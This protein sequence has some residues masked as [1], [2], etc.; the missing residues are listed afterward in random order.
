MHSFGTNAILI[1]LS[2]LLNITIARLLGPEA[3]GGYDLFGAASALL[4]VL[5]GFSLPSG[6]VYV[7]ALATTSLRSMARWS[8]LTALVQSSVV[9][10]GLAIATNYQVIWSFLPREVGGGI[11]LLLTVHVFFGLLGSYWR[12]ILVGRQEIVPANHITLLT[13]LTDAVLLFGLV[14]LLWAQD[15]TINLH[16]IIWLTIIS[17]IVSN[18]LLMRRLRT[19]LLQSTEGASG[20]R[21]AVRYSAPCYLG[22]LIQFFNYRLDIFLVG[23]FVGPGG[24]GLYAL[25]VSLAQL[26]WLPST[27]VSTV[28]LP[29]VAGQ[30]GSVAHNG[31]LTARA[32]RFSLWIGIIG[33]ITFSLVIIPVLP[34]AYGAA[35][36]GSVPAL[37]W[38]M[39]GI[40]VI[41]AAF[42]PASY[43]AA[44]G[45]PHINMWI[46]LTALFVTVTLDLFLIPRLNI[47]GASIASTASYSLTALLTTWAFTRE[48]GVPLREMLFLTAEDT[49]LLHS[50]ARTILRREPSEGIG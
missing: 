19:P 29:A 24:V 18:A 47:I 33:G 44:I 3:K 50:L 39:P 16:S 15:R 46:S 37:L 23:Y 42:I 34:L 38:L 6:I 9:L 20:F 25:A 35:F 13:R 41:G 1:P 48:S 7:T 40:V 45:K 10:V 22:N 11:V 28:L 4:V 27:A 2:F 21:E 31:H 43:I 49:R 36:Q 17:A 32:T 14:F 12:S 26:L 5:V 30:Q 8:F